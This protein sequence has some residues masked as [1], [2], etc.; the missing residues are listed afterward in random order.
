[1]FKHKIRVKWLYFIE[2]YEISMDYYSFI[3]EYWDFM[4]FYNTKNV[5]K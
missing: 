4:R 1:M 2:K 3:N 5:S